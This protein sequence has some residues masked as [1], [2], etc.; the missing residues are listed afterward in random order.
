[1][2]KEDNCRDYRRLATKKISK[3]WLDVDELDKIDEAAAPGKAF[4][5]YGSPRRSLAS[6]KRF[7]FQT[8]AFLNVYRGSAGSFASGMCLISP[9]FK[10]KK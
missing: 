7:K 4:H 1:V 2:L 10:A 3:Q 5:D 9:A 8:L 6:V